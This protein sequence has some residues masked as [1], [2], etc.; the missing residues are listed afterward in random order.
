MPVGRGC[1]PSQPIL[2]VVPA[3]QMEKVVRSHKG[4]RTQLHANGTNMEGPFDA[5]MSAVKATISKMH[6]MGC[7]RVATN[8]RMD[9]RI[10]KTQSMQK[11]IDR[12]EV[13]HPFFFTH[14]R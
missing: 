8:M 3:I 6:E 9:T 1:W 10:D 4:I 5:V 7:V 14:P 13:L 11:K 2:T 12:V